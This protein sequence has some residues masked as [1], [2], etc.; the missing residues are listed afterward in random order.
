MVRSLTTT[1]AYCC[2]FCSKAFTYRYSQ[3][4]QVKILIA[5]EWAWSLDCFLLKILTFSHLYATIVV[6]C[7]SYA[8]PSILKSH[9]QMCSFTVIC[10]FSLSTVINCSVA[11][12]WLNG[13]SLSPTSFFSLKFQLNAS[14]HARQNWTVSYNKLAYKWLW[15]VANQESQILPTCTHANVC[16]QRTQT[17]CSHVLQ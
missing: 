9:M 2:D 16:M 10:T 6:C 13:K 7:K 14:N 1:L 5:E 11:D 17:S 8:K 3:L 15:K 12:V 4:D